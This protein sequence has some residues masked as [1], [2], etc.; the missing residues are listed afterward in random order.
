LNLI[1]FSCEIGDNGRSIAARPK[2]IQTVVIRFHKS[3][4]ALMFAGT[5]LLA[6]PAYAQQSLDNEQIERMMKDGVDLEVIM[7]LL[8]PSINPNDQNGLNYRFDDSPAAIISLQK[9]GKEGNWPPENIKKIQIKISEMSKKDQKNLKELVDRAWNIFENADPD[10]YELIMR[11]LIREGRRVVP[12]LMKGVDLESE[13]KRAGTADALGRIAEKNETVMAVM[14]SMLLDRSKPVREKAAKAMAGLAGE[15][16]MRELIGK[17]GNRSLKLDGVCMALGFIGNE[18]AVEPLAHTLK[19]S[20]DT[21]TRVCAAFALGELRAKLPVAREALLEAVLDEREPDLRVA[22]AEALGRVGE[23]RAPDYMIK[24]YHRYRTGRDELIRRFD[25]FKDVKVLD[26]L[27]GAIEDPDPKVKRAAVETLRLL[28]GEEGTT[29]EDWMA[30]IQILRVRPDWNTNDGSRIPDV[31]GGE[32]GSS[33]VN[34]RIGDPLPTT[35][36]R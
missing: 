17:L 23:P 29:I 12:Y 22:A 31:G 18:Q 5:V 24:A 15:N 11:G 6:G 27:V 36:S 14:M 4:I 9:A 20:P 34:P 16:T 32:R 10:E 33:A 25:H 2:E 8:E 1:A 28:T 30:I 13:R 7:K 19:L 3:V 26:F 21:D 35:S